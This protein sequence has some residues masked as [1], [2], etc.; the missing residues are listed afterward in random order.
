MYSKGKLIKPHDYVSSDFDSVIKMLATE[1][2]VN[3]QEQAPK[4]HS[5]G[6]HTSQ[7]TFANVGVQVAA[8]SIDSS[9]RTSGE[10]QSSWMAASIDDIIYVVG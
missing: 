1:E 6:P 4:A 3:G 7:Y 2:S 8:A 9:L 10:Q 5:S